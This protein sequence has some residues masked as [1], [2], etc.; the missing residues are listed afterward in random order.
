MPR[1][2]FFEWP[3]LPKQGDEESRTLR[4]QNPESSSSRHEPGPGRSTAEQ[5]FNDVR[6]EIAQRN[7]RAHQEARKLRTARER[8]QLRRRRDDDS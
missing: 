4:N 1:P 8:E 5:A 7:E 3:T 6:K 2:A